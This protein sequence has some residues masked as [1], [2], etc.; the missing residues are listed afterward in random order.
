[1]VP[2]YS[3]FAQYRENN[4]VK[5]DEP[6]SSLP[7][8]EKEFETEKVED[9]TDNT[10]DY[11]NYLSS[12]EDESGGQRKRRSSKNGHRDSSKK[13][14]RSSHKRNRRDSRKKNKMSKKSLVW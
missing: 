4:F 11:Q 9:Q 13:R 7:D 14:Q 2:T 12:D 5:A 8:K 6:L 3:K 10:A 1:M